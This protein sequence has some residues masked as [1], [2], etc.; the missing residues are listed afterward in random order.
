MFIYTYKNSQFTHRK[1]D[2]SSI[3]RRK[4]PLN[5]Y[6]N[7]YYPLNSYKNGYNIIFG[8]MENSNEVIQI[9]SNFVP[10]VIKNSL[11]TETPKKMI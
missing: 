8:K 11:L 10:I 1:T 6:K 7:G 5:S 9:P 3:F 2:I 4:K